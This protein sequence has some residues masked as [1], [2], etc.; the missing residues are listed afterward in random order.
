MK[1]MT[2]DILDISKENI[3]SVKTTFAD[4]IINF[5]RP[6]VQDYEDEKIKKLSVVKNEIKNLKA[7]LASE[8]EKIN[9]MLS[10]HKKQEKISKLLGRIDKIVDTG[11]TYG[12]TKRELVIVLKILNKLPEEKIDVQLRNMMTILSK[13]LSRETNFWDGLLEY[14]EGHLTT[15]L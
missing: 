13:G 4:D 14:L 6:I 11:L 3:D 15:I 9:G 10:E 5:F 1:I 7:R 8:K 2:S 12:S